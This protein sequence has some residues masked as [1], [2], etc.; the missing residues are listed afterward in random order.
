[1]H[2]T[3]PEDAGGASCISSFD[4]PSASRSSR[5]MA[6]GGG[7]DDSGGGGG[8]G[9]GGAG[10]YAGANGQSEQSGGPGP[11]FPAT[12]LVGLG[13]ACGVTVGPAVSGTKQEGMEA[14]VVVAGGCGQNFMRHT[15]VEYYNPNTKQWNQLAPMNSSRGFCT[16]VSV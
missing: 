9:G 3:S 5:G 2:T 14:V 1:M 8:G 11:A 12:K 7:S 4:H 10:V 6:A 15:S 13:V 16:M